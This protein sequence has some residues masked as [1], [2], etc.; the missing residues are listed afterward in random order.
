M[1]TVPSL[2]K[3]YRAI[4]R[5]H[6]YAG[7]IVAPF[8]V[9]LSV[10]GAIY[11]F[12]EEINDALSPELRFVIPRAAP[13]PVSDMIRA[14]LAAH[15]GAATRIDL[16]ATP[17]RAATVFVTPD[18][19]E[20]L[21]I[22]VDPGDARV[23]G[24]YVYER[25]LV[26]FADD[27]HGSLTI[28]TIGD[29][30]VELAACWALVLIATGLYLWWPRSRKGPAGLLYPRLWAKGRLFWRDLHASV[31]VWTVALIA[32]L[33]L[34][35][36]PW[37]GVQGDLLKQVTAAADIG[38]PA[39][40]RGYGAPK[41]VPMKAALREAP[42]TLEDAPMPVSDATHADHPGHGLMPAMQDEAAV[43]GI[44]D[45]VQA[46]ADHRLA[47]GYRLFLPAGPEGVYT[48]YT[49]PDQPQGQRTLYFDRY[50][51][52][53][54]REIRYADYGWA[55]KAIE[56]GVQL[57]MGNYFGRANQIL[58][59]IPCIGIVLL[60]V[61]GVIM[62][63]KRRPAGRLG[64]PPSISDVRMKGAI[65]LLIIAGVVMP[66]LG[67]SLIAVFLI[68]LMVQQLRRPRS[69]REE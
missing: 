18:A 67:L 56:L 16:P 33:I 4:W 63:W 50:S 9:I 5:W 10:T 62:W 46:A 54:I 42:W 39:S 19:G 44:D 25:T 2:S 11:L 12:N 3:T 48:A 26:G 14:A 40:T 37:A 61:S 8:L 7:L 58:M 36:L 68:D 49:Y 64:A 43:S 55:A 45:I 31:G 15:P 13:T 47:S 1:A 22:A 60:V 66:L 29:R 32:F 41:S 23:L 21:R 6:F 27:M 34:T 65:A 57:H 35:G 24:S 28:G 59:L 30:I 20:A 38:Y 17:D 51:G 52:H 69:V 53:L